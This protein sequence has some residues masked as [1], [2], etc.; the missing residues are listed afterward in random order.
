MGVR[1]A[2]GLAPQ[3]AGQAHV[4]RVLGLAR[5]LLWT[6]HAAQGLSKHMV[7]RHHSPLVSG[8]P[9]RYDAP[10]SRARIPNDYARRI[11]HRAT[12][13]QRRAARGACARSPD[14]RRPAAL[15]PGPDGDEGGVQRR[16]VRRVHG[17]ARRRDHRVVHHPGGCKRTGPR[18]R[19]SRASRRTASST[20]FS[21]ASSTTAASSAA[22]ARRGRSWRRSRFWT[23]TPSPT[24]EQVKAWMMGNLCRCTGYYQI[25]E[26]IMKA[27]Q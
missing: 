25:L 20:R 10:E 14:A 18:S 11:I 27:A 19:P 8:I 4:G 26:S 24:E 7:C 16:R 21:R 23:P 13:C 2:Q 5:D 6:V 15:R 22:S 17:A 3:H 9:L 1:A 12:D